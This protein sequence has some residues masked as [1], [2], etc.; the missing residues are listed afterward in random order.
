[1]L[2]TK[3]WEIRWKKKAAEK[4]HVLIIED[5][6]KVGSKLANLLEHV[7]KKENIFTARGYQ[8]V[9]QKFPGR[10]FDAVLY[11]TGYNIKACETFCESNGQQPFIISLDRYL[12]S[13]LIK[14]G[15][16]HFV[17]RCFI[18]RKECIECI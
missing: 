18:V 13:R 3:N 16:G 8:D 6:E 12:P 11:N 4:M 5:Q 1:M 10:I 17:N 7:F 14:K 2:R 9:I 15:D